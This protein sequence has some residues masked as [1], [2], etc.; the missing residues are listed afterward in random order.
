MMNKFLGTAQLQIKEIIAYPF[1]LFI[2]G[3]LNPVLLAVYY[4]LWKAIYAYSGQLALR[5][6]A[7]NDLVIYY[8]LMLVINSFTWTNV[9]IDMAYRIKD[10]YL[11]PK[12]VRPI[13]VFLHELYKKIGET[14]MVFTG[15]MLP[16]LIVASVFFG[17]HVTSYANTFFMAISAV[18]SLLLTF[19]FTFFM[20]ISSFWI[21]EYIGIRHLRSGLMWFLSGAFVPITFFPAAWQKASVFL[22]FQ[23]M[24]FTPIQIFLGK[25]AFVEILQ[26][27]AV[28]VVWIIIFLVLIKVCWKIALRHFTAVGQ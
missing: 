26:Q 15:Q 4:F 10:G 27:I 24:I 5:G 28:Q 12:L 21:T 9:D 22:P 16:T 11:T 3:I 8:A 18:L 23:H 2:W 1:E 13:S 25:Y 20:G 7:F 14:A 6:M 19:S 17:F